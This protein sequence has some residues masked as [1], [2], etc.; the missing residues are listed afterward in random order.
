VRTALCGATTTVLLLSDPQPPA[1]TSNKHVTTFRILMQ[2]PLSSILQPNKTP[3][4][5]AS[6]AFA[7]ERASASARPLPANSLAANLW[8]KRTTT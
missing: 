2:D 5:A 4:I 7:F 8:P 1:H 6:Y 3:A